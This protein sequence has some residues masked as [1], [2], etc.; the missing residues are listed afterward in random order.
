[1]IQLVQ[2][3]LKNVRPAWC[4]WLTRLLYSGRRVK[5]GRNFR[6][7]TVPRII[8]DKNC[9]L[10]IGDNVEFRRNIEIRVHGSS[11]IN[12]ENNVRID[13]GVRLLAANKSEIN[14]REGVRIGLYTVFNGGDSIEVGKKA[15]VS[16]FVYLQ[17][18][19]HG[20][21]SKGQ[22]VQDQGYQHA[23]VTLESDAWLGTH[24]VVLPGVVIGKGAVVGS[25]AVVTKNVDSYQVVAG[26][27]AK[28]IKERE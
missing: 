24:V 11:K 22:F 28:A 27:P 21:A 1:M 17:T 23:P 10:S 20:F 14:I 9:R 25:N 18:S 8:V 26:I 4:A 7:D 13:R 16:G 12:V 19:M 6:T 15:L 5:I 2:F 3:Y